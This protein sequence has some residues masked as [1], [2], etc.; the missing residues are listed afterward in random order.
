MKQRTPAVQIT[1]GRNPC[2]VRVV[3]ESVIA[4]A[5][6]ACLATHASSADAKKSLGGGA[7][8]ASPKKK[9]VTKVTQ[10]RSPSEETQAER[11]RRMYRE[12]KGMH[13]AGAC[14]GYTR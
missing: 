10:Q 9:G 11:D 3:L 14:R 2:W 5:I 4:V 6:A 12:C 8:A 13:N 7:P 1:G